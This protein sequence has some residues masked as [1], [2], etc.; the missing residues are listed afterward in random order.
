MRELISRGETANLLGCSRPTVKTR[1]G[2]PCAIILNG[3]HEL[4]AYRAARVM[5]FLSG[6]VIAPPDEP[7]AF[8]SMLEAARR[9]EICKYKLKTLLGSAD[10]LYILD[11]GREL[12]VWSHKSICAAFSLVQEARQAGNRSFDR[13]RAFKR[14]MS[15]KQ[16]RRAQLR[17]MD[18]RSLI[19]PKPTSRVRM[20]QA[21]HRW[22]DPKAVAAC[23]VR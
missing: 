9:L 3:R 18:I 16:R 10:C 21:I 6:Q 13:Q 5:A 7:L 11:G 22:A 15:A 12:A 17:R 4:P 14:R 23:R 8:Y 19:R 20:V 1:L 2:K